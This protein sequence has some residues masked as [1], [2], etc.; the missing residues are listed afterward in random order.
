MKTNVCRVWAVAALLMVCV[1]GSAALAA[2]QF[3]GSWALTLP[4]GQA[5]WLGVSEE[6]GELSASLM[7]IAGS[8]TPVQSV[9][10]KGDKLIL[11]RTLKPRR[12]KDGAGATEVVQT[13]TAERVGDELRVTLVST[14]NVGKPKESKFTGKW[15]PPVSAKPDLA[16]IEWGSPITLFDGTS[17]DG[18]KLTNPKQVNGWSIEDGCLV[19]TPT[20]PDDG[21][22]LSY[23]NL[24]TVGEFEDFKLTLEVNV[25]AKENSGIYLRGIY[26][27][28]VS[29]SFD[30]ELHNSGSL[31]SI[32]S[33]VA[34]V[35]KA[36]KPGGTWQTMEIILLD[37]HVNV[38]LN[39]ETIHDN[40]P[41]Q[42]CTGGALWS[43]PFKPGP[44]Y[45]QGDHTGI[46]YRNIVLRPCQ[47]TLS[48][49]RE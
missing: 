20:Q 17:L 25:Q 36:E 34:P 24:R 44:I 6:Q 42:G 4:N 21:H 35:K 43:D 14:P 40:V 47:A 46:R 33:R 49:S 28:Q 48:D 2:E 12:A 8:V 39:G 31:G 16:R 3:T 32:Y 7:W 22:H 23:G 26:E 41:V 38:V 19:N 13:F 11:V 1:F 45:L 5:G 37:R 29:D 15:C 30:S 18:W 27:L 10:V 9:E